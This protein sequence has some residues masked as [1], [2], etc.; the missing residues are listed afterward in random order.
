[1]NRSTLLRLTLV[2]IATIGIAAPAIGLAKDDPFQTKV[3]DGDP[4]TS[5]S[6]F[7]TLPAMHDEVE[8]ALGET[9]FEI[10]HRFCAPYSGCTDWV[11]GVDQD[12]QLATPSEDGEEIVPFGLGVSFNVIYHHD[13]RAGSSFTSIWRGEEDDSRY[14]FAYFLAHSDGYP[15]ERYPEW[16][17]DETR[18]VQSCIIYQ[19]ACDARSLTVLRGTPDVGLGTS[20]TFAVLRGKAGTITQHCAHIL[21]A[22]SGLANAKTGETIEYEMGAVARF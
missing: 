20:K 14:D 3:C 9:R 8:R 10:R 6:A 7:R 18:F 12:G 17:K 11:A 5:E 15:L 4:M 16:I 13:R 2:L 1:M 22:G 21:L 19:H